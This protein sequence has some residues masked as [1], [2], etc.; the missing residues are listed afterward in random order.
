MNSK[1]LRLFLGLGAATWL[2]A[3]PGV[4][5]PWSVATEVMEGLGAKI[6]PQDP[7]L[8]YWLRMASGAFGLI[9]CLYLILMIS[10]KRFAA[11]IPW[12]GAL[13]LMEGVILL[14]HGLRLD[15]RPWPFYGDV[16]ACLVSGGGV[17]LCWQSGRR[18]KA[19]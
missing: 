4:F 18:E 5:L 2:A 19:G 9:G 15:L 3:A 14:W 12:M 7:M 11:M 6:V 13:G 1:L 8:D 10:P 17:L 16:A